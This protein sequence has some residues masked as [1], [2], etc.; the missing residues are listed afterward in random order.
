MIF[1]NMHFIRQVLK[2]R[3]TGPFPIGIGA[4]N[5]NCPLIPRMVLDFYQHSIKAGMLQTDFEH[6][7]FYY[8]AI[9]NRYETQEGFWHYHSGL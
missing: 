7:D 3:Q 2:K 5:V 9:S 6:H 1:Q 8:V 4:C